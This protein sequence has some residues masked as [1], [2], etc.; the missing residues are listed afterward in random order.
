MTERKECAALGSISRSTTVT[1]ISELAGSNDVEPTTPVNENLDTSYTSN[2]IVEP[3]INANGSTEHQGDALNGGASFGQGGGYSSATTSSENSDNR[4]R[5]GVQTVN[6]TYKDCGFRTYNGNYHGAH[7]NTTGGNSN[8]IPKNNSFSSSSSSSG[9]HT[10]SP[11]NSDSCSA[12]FPESF[13]LGEVEEGNMTFTYNNDVD[14]TFINNIGQLK[15][16]LSSPLFS[17]AVPPTPAHGIIGDKVE[18]EVH[19]KD[20]SGEPN[21]NSADRIAV[22]VYDRNRNKVQV[23][24]E[25]SPSS[26][27][28]SFSFDDSMTRI[29]TNCVY[30]YSFVPTKPGNHEIVIKLNDI[31]ISTSPSTFLC[32]TRLQLSF[33][34]TQPN[35]E[36][37][38]FALSHSMSSSSSIEED[39][40]ED[41]D[42]CH[43][44]EM[45]GSKCWVIQ[46][47]NKSALLQ[48]L[49]NHPSDI[50]ADQQVEGMCGWQVLAY[51]LPSY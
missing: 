26:A 20:K 7:E 15:E 9:Y 43:P 18:F 45:G 5:N 1:N 17:L 36:R 11:T 25:S 21:Y 39:K 34:S 28:K 19:T 51:K 50:Y 2:G 38:H 10:S 37:E 23:D 29:G 3:W 13:P 42:E 27:K 14:L 40:E 6:G 8:Q 41:E 31:H 48:S 22:R 16:N 44:H 30:R 33:T 49:C 35:E 12:S 47:D 32:Y 46:K 4:A 24:E